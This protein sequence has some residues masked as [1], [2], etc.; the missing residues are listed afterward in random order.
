MISDSTTGTNEIILYCRIVRQ[1]GTNT[2]FKPIMYALESSLFHH[3]HTN[4]IHY[5][6][7][8]LKLCEIHA[9]G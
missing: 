4:D 6:A 1:Y 9:A 5:F 2:R 8:G 3:L 7:A